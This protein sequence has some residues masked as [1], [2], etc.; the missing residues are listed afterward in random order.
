MYDTDSING[1]QLT[2]EGKKMD[3]FTKETEENNL[4]DPKERKIASKTQSE[5][6]ESAIHTDG[7][8][9]NKNATSDSLS[10]CWQCK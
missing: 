6:K 5:N 9:L 10:S 1:K 4:F 8:N 7:L 2:P 3:D